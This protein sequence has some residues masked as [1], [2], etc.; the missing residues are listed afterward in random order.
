MVVLGRA[1]YQGLGVGVPLGH[2]HELASHRDTED[3]QMRSRINAS[4]FE[5]DSQ[6]AA[7]NL[8]EKIAHIKSSTIQLM[9]RSCPIERRRRVLIQIQRPIETKQMSMPLSNL[10]FVSF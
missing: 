9:V 8:P 2:E 1:G 5:L 7:Y 3:L 4:P 10:S 6:Y